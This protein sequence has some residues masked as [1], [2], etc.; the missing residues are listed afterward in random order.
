LGPARFVIGHASD[1][2]RRKQLGARKSIDD[3]VHFSCRIGEVWLRGCAGIGQ[4]GYGT[5][6]GPRLIRNSG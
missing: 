5:G 1:R 4:P 3:L 2:E 6:K